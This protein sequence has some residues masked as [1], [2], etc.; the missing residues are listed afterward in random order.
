VFFAEIRVGGG[1][2]HVR[3]TLLDKKEPPTD[4]V[5]RFLAMLRFDSREKI[6]GFYIGNGEIGFLFFSKS[7][8]SPLP[9]L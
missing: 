5:E 3:D 9:F 8:S 1:S 7:G 4:N 6:K 2:D